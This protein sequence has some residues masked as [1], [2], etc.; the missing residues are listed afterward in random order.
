MSETPTVKH[1]LSGFES[2]ALRLIAVGEPVVLNAV[3]T[4]AVE[5]LMRF[6]Y[7]T[8]EMG[9]PCASDEGLRVLGILQ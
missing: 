6:G 7:L 4:A 9:Q 3:N 2:K 8:L 1:A 5:N